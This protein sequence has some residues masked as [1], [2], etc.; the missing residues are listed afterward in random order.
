[1]IDGQVLHRFGRINGWFFIVGRLTEIA[2]GVAVDIIQVDI[3]VGGNG[4]MQAGTLTGRVSNLLGV[5]APCKLLNATER[6]RGTLVGFTLHNVDTV[7]DGIVVDSSHEGMGDG[8]NVMV[9]MTVVQVCDDT[10]GSLG[11]VRRI[12]LDDVIIGN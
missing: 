6:S 8:L 4:V 12:L 5:G 3:G 7:G 2:G 9:P 11:Q 10:A 1:M